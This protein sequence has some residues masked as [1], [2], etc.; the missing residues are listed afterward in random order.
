MV[1]SLLKDR[2]SKKP[3]GAKNPTDLQRNLTN[4]RKLGKCSFCVRWTTE[5]ARPLVWKVWELLLFL[6]HM[7]GI[8]EG[9][10]VAPQSLLAQQLLTTRSQKTKNRDY[11]IKHHIKSKGAWKKR[12]MVPWRNDNQHKICAPFSQHHPQQHFAVS[13]SVVSVLVLQTFE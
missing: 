12:D 9:P 2:P 11:E 4:L 13:I 5:D 10:P 3:F 7:L 6:W 1:K 8:N